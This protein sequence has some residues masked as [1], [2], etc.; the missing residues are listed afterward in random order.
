MRTYRI[1]QGS[2]G[3]TDASALIHSLKQR[4]FGGRDPFEAYHL[5]DFVLV[6]KG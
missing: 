3:L 4:V 5:T 2:S 6:F 1:A